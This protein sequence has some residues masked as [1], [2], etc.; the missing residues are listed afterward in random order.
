MT[1]SIDP[2]AAR[3][4]I[5]DARAET[6]TLDNAA[7]T[8][9]DRYADAIAAAARAPRTAQALTN[10]AADPFL[11][12]LAALRRR[13]VEVTDTAGAV[14][15]YAIGFGIL[16]LGIGMGLFAILT[17]LGDALPLAAQR[18]GA[19]VVFAF[20]G[21]TLLS[22]FWFPR[23]LTPRWFREAGTRRR[24]RRKA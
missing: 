24:G 18:V 1:W 3:A 12:S 7:T 8:T 10:L 21:T 13:V 22:L 14:I 4:V 16:F 2:P 9:S 6:A 11:V 5:S 23:A 17:A 20:L 19:V 15:F